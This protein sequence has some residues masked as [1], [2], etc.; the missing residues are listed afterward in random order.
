MC[1][2]GLCTKGFRYVGVLGH[3]I[4]VNGEKIMRVRFTSFCCSNGNLGVF[5][6]TKTIVFESTV[7]TPNLYGS[8][9]P[10]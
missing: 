9:H 7:R 3:N 6:I 2:R 5:T 8:P 1:V 4:S 10:P